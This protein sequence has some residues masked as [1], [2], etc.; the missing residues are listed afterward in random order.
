MSFSF[1]PCSSF[2][3]PL[4]CRLALYL[5]CH[6]SLFAFLPLTPYR[7]RELTLRVYITPL[8][9]LAFFNTQRDILVIFFFLV[10]YNYMR[11]YVVFL[12]IFFSALFV[13]SFSALRPFFFLPPPPSAILSSVF[14]VCVS[15]FC[16]SLSFIRVHFR[17]SSPLLVPFSPFP[18]SFRCFKDCVSASS[19]C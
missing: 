16:S 13:R 5:F 1:S 7:L 9:F 11:T 10:T 3:V 15:S 4:A 18:T 6:T 19:L 14:F 12:R 2:L 17:T 8:S